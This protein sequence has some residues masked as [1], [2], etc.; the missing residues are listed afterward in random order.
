MPI[1]R[2]IV[3]L[4][5]AFGLIAACGSGAPGAPQEAA[6]PA[7][8]SAWRFA[9][10][11]TPESGHLLSPN[12]AKLAWT[13]SHWMRRTLFV[14]D[15]ADGTTRRYRARGA[16]IWTADSRR[17]IYASDTSGTENPHVF[18]IDTESSADAVDLTPHA[19]V[20]AALHQLIEGDAQH[21]LIT[22]NRRNPK[23]FDLYRVNL[24]TR[25]ETLV[26]ANP[27]DAVAPLTRA[28]GALQGWQAS[29]EAQRPVEEKQRPQAERQTEPAARNEVHL[30]IL[31]PA[32]EPRVAWALSNRGRDRVAL[33]AL[34]LGRGWERVAFEDPIADVAGAYI[35]RITRA[36][37]VVIAHPGY[38]RVELPDPKLRAMLD[39]LLQRFA[40]A[41]YG[42]DIVSSDREEKRFIVNLYTSTQNETWLVDRERAGTELLG[43]GVP[44]DL[45]DALAPLRH[46]TFPARDG[47]PLKG[48]LALPRDSAGERRPLVLMVHGGPWARNTWADP[49]RAEETARAQLFANRG[50]AVLQ[51]DFRGSTGYGRAFRDAAIGEFGKRMQDDL[52]DAV[53]WAVRAGHADP[54]RVAILGFSYGGYAALNALA[55]TPRKFACGISIAGPTDLASLIEAFPPYWKVDLSNWH[56]FVGNP[57]VPADR[58]EMALRSPLTHAAAIERPVLL[59]HGKRD[60]RVRIEQSERMA[61][62]MTA[63]A[64]PVRLVRIDDMGHSASWWAHR[65][66]ILRETE[67]FLGS[68]LGGRVRDFEWAD[69]LV[70]GWTRLSR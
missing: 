40:G 59:I 9:S 11:G 64:R 4:S 60:V 58:A 66:L 44:V 42:L 3:V 39:P 41:P 50:Y 13:G 29:R 45:A 6:Q 69:P 21:V 46:V 20:R 48:Y 65:Y 35:S 67:K 28:D 7:R 30:R 49:L 14:R 57:N 12:G 43:R 38:P 68:C 52:H 5:L 55:A 26:A 53:D 31:G 33:V 62:A 61:A 2:S 47:L 36:P 22:H 56:D 54:A 1:S 27:G 17:L 63:A 34:D 10:P 18:V 25:A 16:V 70:W 24:E 37:L 51:V 23:L 19:G 8:L 32:P 15:L